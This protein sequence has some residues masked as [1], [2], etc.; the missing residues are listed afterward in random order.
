MAI[1][2]FGGRERFTSGQ[3]QILIESYILYYSK[4]IPRVKPGSLLVNG[5]RTPI[6]PLRVA[7]C[8]PCTTFLH[9]ASLTYCWYSLRNQWD[10]DIRKHLFC[11]DMPMLTFQ[12]ALVYLAN[13]LISLEPSTWTN[14]LYLSTVIQYTGMEYNEPSSLFSHWSSPIV[15]IPLLSLHIPSCPYCCLSLPYFPRILYPHAVCVLPRW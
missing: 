5:L 4:L 10:Q 9:F 8:H 1:W 15:D 3:S 12:S 6:V 2:A 11:G 7:S 14:V 13:L